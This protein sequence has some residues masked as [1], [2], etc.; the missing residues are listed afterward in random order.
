MPSSK[1]DFADVKFLALF[2]R[3]IADLKTH[4]QIVGIRLHGSLVYGTQDEYSDVDL[5]VLIA[6]GWDELEI[7]HREFDTMVQQWSPPD[8]DILKQRGY[9]Q[10][11][12]RGIRIINRYVFDFNFEPYDVFSRPEVEKILRAETLDTAGIRD[13]VDGRILYDPQGLCKQLKDMLVEYPLELGRRIVEQRLVL[14]TQNYSAAKT[15]L[16]RRD[17]IAAH[18]HLLRFYDDAMHVLFALNRQWYPAIKHHEKHLTALSRVP[19]GF[20]KRVARLIAMTTAGKWDKAEALLDHLYDDLQ[21]MQEK[22]FG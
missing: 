6:G 10:K 18:Y 4:P 3:I 8:P 15:A 13:I 22:R 1:P 16:G 19:A 20:A 2:D 17:S 5:D 7:M 14:S 12:D 21:I 11:S 9:V